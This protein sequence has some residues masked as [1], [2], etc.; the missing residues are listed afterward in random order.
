MKKDIIDFIYNISLPFFVNNN[1]KLKKNSQ[2]GVI[3][4]LKTKEFELFS[5]YGFSSYVN[6]ISFARN[7]GFNI[8][9]SEI[10]IIYSN[11]VTNYNLNFFKNQPTVLFTDLEWQK[12]VTENSELYPA[13]IS[14]NDYNLIKDLTFEVISRIENVMFPLIE[15]YLSLPFWASFYE[16]K[17]ERIY[18][19]GPGEF[20]SNI[21]DDYSIKHLIILKLCGSPSFEEAF[22]IHYERVKGFWEKFPEDEGTN[23]QMAMIKNLKEILD[24]TSLKYDYKDLTPPYKFVKNNS[25]TVPKSDAKRVITLAGKEVEVEINSF[26]VSEDQQTTI[27]EFLNNIALHF[28]NAKLETINNAEFENEQGQLQDFEDCSF[29]LYSI[30]EATGLLTK[31]PKDF[32]VEAAKY[33]YIKHISIDPDNN[34]AVLTMANTITDQI[35]YAHLTL[36]GHIDIVT[37]D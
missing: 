2:G 5:G 36:S 26:D 29:V 33:L 30:A 12:K 4:T 6:S 14:I 27:D 7:L 31:K 9:I 34:N 21:N 17:K 16:E 8:K 11:I 32:E 18:Q 10:E 13:T 3:F 24:T 19:R 1:L 37:G 20:Y 35:L 28:E 23:S 25:I 22:D 15:N